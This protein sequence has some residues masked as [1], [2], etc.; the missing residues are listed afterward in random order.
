[1]S[2]M[3]YAENP[4]AAHDIHQLKVNLRGV[5]F[6]FYTDAGVFSKTAVDFGT[7]LLLET[8]DFNSE[9]KGRLLDVGCGYGPM[10]LAY[11]KTTGYNVMM[12]D[13]NQ[14]AVA[15]A[16]KNAQLNQI[17]NVEIMQSNL[18][19]QVSGQFVGIISNPPIRAG[20]KVV[21][22]ILSESIQYLQPKGTLTIVIQKKQGASSAKE[23]M[24]SIFGNVTILAKKKGYYI[25]QSVKELD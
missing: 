9:T 17:N 7:Q 8:L 13:I 4:D 15:L 25:L 19:E 20:K 24:N 1:M 18:Y 23:K 12:V 5:P 16:Q 2:Q 10:G 11:A 22:Q 3:Y 6:H 21:H 14:R